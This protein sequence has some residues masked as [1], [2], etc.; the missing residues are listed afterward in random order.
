MST[1]VDIDKRHFDV[2]CMLGK[3]MGNRRV[4]KS[5]LMPH[6][7]LTNILC[8]WWGILFHVVRP[9]VTYFPKILK[10]SGSIMIMFHTYVDPINTI[11]QGQCH[12]NWSKITCNDFVLA[13]S[14]DLDEI[15][16]NS[17]FH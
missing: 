8:L 2:I 16:Q 10:P 15:L 5:S 13:N 4:F 6:K 12:S 11:L 9:S 14:E 1:R 17:M 3:A 7:T